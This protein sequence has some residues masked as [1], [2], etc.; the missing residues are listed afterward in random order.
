M[1][2]L[3]WGLKANLCNSCTINRVQLCAFVAFWAT[4][5]KQSSPQMMTMIGNCGIEG[6]Y[7]KALFESLDLDFSRA[8]I[9]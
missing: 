8:I 3:K 5:V 4:N 6:K 9:P 2:P 1:E 7:P